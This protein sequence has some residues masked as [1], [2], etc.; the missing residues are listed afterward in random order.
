VTI[1]EYEL[2]HGAAICRLI[3]DNLINNIEKYPSGSTGGYLVNGTIGLYIKH[4]SKR[5]SPWRFTLLGQHKKEILEMSIKLEKVFLLL[6]CNTD[7]VACLNFNQL[8]TLIGLQN[9]TPDWISASRTRRKKYLIRG[10]YGTLKVKVGVNRY[11][12]IDNANK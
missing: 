10:S 3:R 1:S 7:G 11:E 2:F 6:V 12:G 5:L 9:I 8:E 4:S